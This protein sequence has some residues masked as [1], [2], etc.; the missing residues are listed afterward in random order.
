MGAKSRSGEYLEF[1]FGELR[2]HCKLAEEFYKTLFMVRDLKA[3]NWKVA[4]D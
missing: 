3:T 4:F 1:R 2:A